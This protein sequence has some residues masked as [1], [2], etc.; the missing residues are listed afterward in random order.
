MYK[1]RKKKGQSADDRNGA[2]LRPAKNHQHS[3]IK[4][5]M[6]QAKQSTD[7]KVFRPDF[8]LHFYAIELPNEILFTYL[9]FSLRNNEKKIGR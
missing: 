3:K 8:F 9:R 1:E 5:K 7:E 2:L 6:K 4:N